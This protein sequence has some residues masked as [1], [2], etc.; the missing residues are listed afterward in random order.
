MVIETPSSAPPAL[1]ALVSSEETTV[2]DEQ[3]VVPCSKKKQEEKP[4]P[5]DPL[6]VMLWNIR[7]FGG[8][9][10]EPVQRDAALI[11]AYAQLVAALKADIVV[12]VGL[13]RTIGK[14]A[15][16]SG[17]TPSGTPLL[18]MEDAVEDTGVAEV[19]RIL[20]KLQSLD[21][22]GGW[23]AQFRENEAKDAYVY[24]FESTTCILH[25]TADGL[26]YSRL[27]VVDSDLVP[28]L[29]LTGKLVCASFDSPKHCAKPINVMAP[30]GAIDA[31]AANE[32]LTLPSDAPAKTAAA[33]EAAVLAL[34]APEDLAADRGAF[35]DFRE[36]MEAVYRLPSSEGSVLRPDYWKTVAETHDGLLAN[37]AAVALDDIRLQDERMHWDAME[38]PKHAV[39]LDEIVG[40]LADTL[41]VRAVDADAAP[42]IEELRVV[43]LVRASLS[44]EALT[45]LEVPPPD[46]TFPTENA[47]LASQAEAFRKGREVPEPKSDLANTLAQARYFS[48]ALSTHWPVVGQLRWT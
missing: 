24:L 35:N 21:S 13:T 34:S 23:E 9:F 19:K 45:E 6:R 29:G 43:D 7:Q 48:L 16:V 11:E 41:L 39:A 25:R 10:N 4:A 38:T 36:A 40:V 18:E 37:F 17:T 20:A 27:D 26:T 8:G 44:S 33:P 42:K 32:T 30:L 31:R 5:K 3:A 15:K 22:A 47:A 28:K 46:E 12:L 2:P 14:V 1:Q